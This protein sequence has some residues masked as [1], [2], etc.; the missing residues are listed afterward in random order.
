M[1][2]GD[3]DAEELLRGYRAALALTAAINALHRTRIPL[4]GGE[5]GAKHL[6][7]LIAIHRLGG[8]APLSRVAREV[9]SGTRR[10]LG[11]LRDLEAAG[12]V[13]VHSTHTRVCAA[14]TDRGLE[15]ARE[16]LRALSHRPEE[17]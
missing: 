6:E 15:A 8:S 12:L 5:I 17:R 7:A 16:L 1:G 10:A 13:R 14:L 4:A 2:G 9:G 3:A 11:L